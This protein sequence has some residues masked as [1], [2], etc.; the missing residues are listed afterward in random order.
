MP[1]TRKVERREVRTYKGAVYELLI[2]HHQLTIGGGE[3]EVWEL[4]RDGEQVT[5]P[6]QA[7]RLRLQVF[8]RAR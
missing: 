6:K 7:A 2:L 8:G 1:D 5:A 4:W 3:D